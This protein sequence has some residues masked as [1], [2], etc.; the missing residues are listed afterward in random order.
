MRQTNMLQSKTSNNPKCSSKIE[1]KRERERK[2]QIFLNK[3]KQK[4]SIYFNIYFCGVFFFKVHSNF[5][6]FKV[7]ILQPMQKSMH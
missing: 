2:K 5:D 1:R 7:G 4:K 6:K 3:A